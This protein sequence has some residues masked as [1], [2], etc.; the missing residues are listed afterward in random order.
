[1]ISDFT[2]STIIERWENL[3]PKGVLVSAGTLESDFPPLTA[4]EQAS[5]GAANGKRTRELEAGRMHA[6][7]ALEKMGIYNV[8]IPKNK[9]TGAPI[10]PT[11]VVG[12]IT[13][14]RSVNNSHVAAVVAN[15][16]QFHLLGIDA[17][18]C[19]QIYPYMW[20]QFL[21]SQELYWI[22]EAPI[23]ER[24]SLACKAWTLKEA[25]IK[26]TGKGDMMTWIVSSSSTSLAFELCNDTISGEKA[27]Q[28]SAV[29]KQDLVLA[30]VYTYAN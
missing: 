24:N 8:D 17:E 20:A 4:K 9:L 30:V 5:I 3:I 21:T 6:R 23:P 10:W 22:N 28:G 11:S 16:N 15:S 7:Q 27:L 1:M 19:D 18:W 2:R 14:S 12:S 26:A 25:A 13:H 29:C